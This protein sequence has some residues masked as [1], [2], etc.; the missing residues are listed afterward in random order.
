MRNNSYFDVDVVAKQFQLDSIET[1][2]KDQ[3]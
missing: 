1:R 2:N 3:R